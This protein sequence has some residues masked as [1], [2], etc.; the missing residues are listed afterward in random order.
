MPHIQTLVSSCMR[1]SSSK[2]DSKASKL[3]SQCGRRDGRG[4]T[5]LA[6]EVKQALEQDVEGD[7]EL[8]VDVLLRGRLMLVERLDIEKFFGKTFGKFNLVKEIN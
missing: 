2:P 6:G 1:N 4:G 5:L 8:E 3:A 7:V